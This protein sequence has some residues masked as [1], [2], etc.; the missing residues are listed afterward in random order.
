[1]W[2]LLLLGSCSAYCTYTQ[3]YWL[4]S[5]LGANTGPSGLSL[6]NT[7]WNTIM[8]LD[9]FQ[10][11]EA[12]TAYWLMVFH[13]LYTG[14]YN[15]EF[16]ADTYTL[17]VSD[18]NPLDDYYDTSAV[19]LSLLTLTDS[20][21]RSCANIS[22]WAKNARYDPNVQLSLKTLV[23]FNDGI[24][25][26]GGCTDEF[27]N[28]TVF[29]F[30]HESDL[31]IANF[32]VYPL[33]EAR[34]TRLYQVQTLL[35]IGCGLAYCFLLPALVFYLILKSN[36][37]RKYD[38]LLEEDVRAVSVTHPLDQKSETTEKMDAVMARFDNVALSSGSDTLSDVETK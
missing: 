35:F 2:L 28:V 25:L 8:A 20:L 29:S 19:N 23:N 14:Y 36:E 26:P 4:Q 5:A 18:I 32:N 21:Q 1:M 12:D 31:F 10:V 15:S 13:Q 37:Q 11:R 6:C 9:C 17:N 30:A 3:S 16:I 7:D 27:A 34:V 22:Q 38:W 24:S 33:N